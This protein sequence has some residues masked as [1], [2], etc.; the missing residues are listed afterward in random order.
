[1]LKVIFYFG[2]HNHF[3][4][5]LVALVRTCDHNNT[6]LNISGHSLVTSVLARMYCQVRKVETWKR[7]EKITA[8]SLE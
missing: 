7:K 5:V 6:H 1:M 3:F 8:I 4:G 2:R